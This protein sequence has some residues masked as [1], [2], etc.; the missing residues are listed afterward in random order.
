MSI[1]CTGGD[2][3]QAVV[4]KSDGKTDLD[5]IALSHLHT[6]SIDRKGVKVFEPVDDKDTA[7]DAFTSDNFGLGIKDHIVYG[8]RYNAVCLT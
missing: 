8:T 5:L 3:Q 1:D 6:S 2:E 4:L 7:Q